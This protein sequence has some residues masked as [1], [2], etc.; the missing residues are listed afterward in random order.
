MIKHITLGILL[1]LF[2]ITCPWWVTVIFALVILYYL[3]SFNEIVIFGLLMDI[4]YG[5][6][7][8]HFSIWDFKFTLFF[9]ILLLSSFFIKKR[10]RF[11]L[12]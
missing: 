11:Y 8:A 1:F 9:L 6:F 3:K 10:L 2:I 7:S 12:K 4:M 5:N